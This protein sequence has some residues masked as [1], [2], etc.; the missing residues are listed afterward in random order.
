MDPIWLF[1]IGGASALVIL[2]AIV[3][4]GRGARRF[5]DSAAYRTAG[6]P[7]APLT[8]SI[9]GGTGL[10]HEVFLRWS[11]RW[12]GDPDG[13]HVTLRVAVHVGGREL[14][15]ATFIVGDDEYG[16]PLP[17]GAVR[18]LD[19][20]VTSGPSSGKIRQADAI[21]RLEARPAGVESRVVVIA[22]PR[23]SAQMERLELLA[24]AVS[25]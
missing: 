15:A 25:A 23:P 16:S 14:H 17:V 4:A 12:S 9:P 10:A 13:D 3:L 11:A 1:V 18:G 2:L 8:L 22:A 7:G 24:I 5:L 21:V 20:S 19:A 6:P